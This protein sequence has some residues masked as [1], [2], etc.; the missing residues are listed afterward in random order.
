MIIYDID[1]YIFE[2]GGKY[3]TSFERRYSLYWMKK[4]NLIITTT[5]YL[6]E[7][8]SE[9]DKCYIRKNAIPLEEFNKYYRT[10]R[11]RN[12]NGRNI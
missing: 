2:E 8:N 9:K 5:K 7:I 12:E 11:I 1:D 6:L 3:N 10:K 4:A